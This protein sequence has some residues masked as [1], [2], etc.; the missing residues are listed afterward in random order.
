MHTFEFLMHG[1][2]H[3]RKNSIND[4]LYNDNNSR[5]FEVILTPFSR[6]MYT[7]GE[8]LRVINYM[9]NKEACL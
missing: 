2:L 8:R 4:T 7:V 3:V 5:R 6:Y 1:L 9:L